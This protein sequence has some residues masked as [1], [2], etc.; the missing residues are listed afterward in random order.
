MA[1]L[2]GPPY[3]GN[4]GEPIDWGHWCRDCVNMSLKT[5]IAQA[6]TGGALYLVHRIL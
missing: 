6:L 3:C 4:C 5:L 2:N 1:R